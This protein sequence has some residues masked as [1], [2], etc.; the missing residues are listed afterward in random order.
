[1]AMASY[2]V[3]VTSAAPPEAVFEV[4]ADATRWHEWAGFSVSTSTWEREGDPAPG[5]VGAIR[6][7]GRPPV[8]G[9]EQILEFEPPF[10]LAYTIVSG[11][12]VRGYHADVDLRPDGSGTVIR[13]SAAFEPKVPGTGALL[14][15]VLRRVILGYATR[16]AAEAERRI[17]P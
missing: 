16:A 15:E 7:L 2:D 1:V 13:W 6:R 11:I 14:A 5:G 4:I 3:T 10:H 8:Y 12:P 17:T 9:R